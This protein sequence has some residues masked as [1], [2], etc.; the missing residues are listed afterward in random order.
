MPDYRW[1]P[2]QELSDTERAI[3]LASIQPLYETW[4]QSRARLQESSGA[5]LQR[6]TERLVRRLSV[7]TGILERLYDLDRGTTEALVAKGFVEDLV[8]RS[9]T[10]IEPSRLIDILK[11][12]EAAIQCVMDAVTGN[13]DLTRDLIHNLHAILTRHQNTTMAVDPL[14]N[15][16]EIPLL[17]GRFKE[18]AN[19]PRR[20]DGAIHEYCPPVQVESEMDNLLDWLS[21]SSGA[22]PVILATWFHHRF[23]Q[24]HPYQDGNGRVARTLTTL[25]LLRADLLPL[26][27]DR[28]LRSDYIG[29]LE[30]ADLGNLEPLTT[31]FAS[32]E[33]TAI[34][35]ALSVDADA[36]ISHEK[37]LTAT[38]IDTLADKFG[39]RKRQKDQQ[40][41]KVDDLAMILRQRTRG[42]I[43]EAL[44]RLKEPVSNI[45]AQPDIH[46]TDGG[47]DRANAHWYKFEVVQSAI[48]AKTFANFDEN[49]Y[50]VK[51]SFRAGRERLIFVTSFHHVGRELSGIMEATAFARLESFEQS[52]DRDSVSHDFFVCS[53]EPF[54][55]TYRTVHTDITDSFSRWLDAALA[56]AV[57]EYGDRL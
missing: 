34:L 31:L 50:F 55:L 17:K 57:K 22:D 42:Y 6:F 5:S 36:E 14:G 52:D 15:R 32:L 38:V 9:S 8:S 41:R 24:I 2:I 25:V 43:E 35:Q 12:Q 23:T 21:Q 39:R 10:D 33:R 51:A 28:D 27:I 44:N 47:P 54:V 3:D 45:I 20:P 37:T 11:D 18:Q 30:S 40:F 29:A 19:N 26:V 4:R 49:H 13:R 1:S 7:E 56:V 48:A 16:H 53:L 46:I